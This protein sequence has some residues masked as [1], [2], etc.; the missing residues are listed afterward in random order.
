MFDSIKNFLK[1][2]KK[3]Q[4][5]TKLTTII[6]LSNN[7]FIKAES[8]EFQTEIIEVKKEN[9]NLIHLFCIGNDNYWFNESEEEIWRSTFNP[10]IHKQKA[11]KQIPQYGIRN[12][13][14]L[15]ILVERD[16]HNPFPHKFYLKK[17]VLRRMS[18]ILKR[19]KGYKK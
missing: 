7:K 8:K 14:A 19:I 1:K 6:Q 9:P 17:D 15:G 5:K 12:L 3:K 4:V 2:S 18:K 10:S 16:F 11:W 13:L